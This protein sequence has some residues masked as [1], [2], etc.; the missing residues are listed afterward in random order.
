MHRHGYRASRLDRVLADAGVTKGALYHHFGGKRALGLAVVEEI[1]RA[2]ISAMWI[3]PLVGCTDPITTLVERMAWG[4]R[5]ASP[6]AIELGCP[7]H[8]LAQEMSAVDEGFR[9]RLEAVL[10]DWREE[11]AA[12][13]RRGQAN[14]AVAGTVLPDGTA[15]FIVA[16]WQGS[17]ALAK[18][19]RSRQTLAACRRGLESYL[20]TLRP[21]PR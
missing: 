6:A 19:D 1:V 17:T 11:L 21:P 7:L 13:L 14:G 10:R 12:A 9:R 18:S 5:R 4:E 15:A 20:E 2:R 3:E 16:V 8:N